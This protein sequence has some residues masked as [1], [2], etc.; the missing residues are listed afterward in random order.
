MTS[1]PKMSKLGESLNADANKNEFKHN[2]NAR[3]LE[4]WVP[5]QDSFL[6][7][8]VSLSRRREKLSE[9]DRVVQFILSQNFFVRCL[10]VVLAH[11]GSVGDMDEIYRKC[12]NF[13]HGPFLPVERRSIAARWDQLIREADI[14]DPI[15]LLRDFKSV[16][17]VCV[18]TLII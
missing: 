11:R 9:V 16:K 6:D 5:L 12:P 2:P 1:P 3:A 15:Q 7:M 13:K 17:K 4:D 14:L 18:V 10:N 8:K